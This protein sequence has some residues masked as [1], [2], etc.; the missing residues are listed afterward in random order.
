[1][2]RLNATDHHKRINMNNRLTLQKAAMAITEADSILITAG[3]G[4]LDRP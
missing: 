4:I 1:M 3:A 2:G